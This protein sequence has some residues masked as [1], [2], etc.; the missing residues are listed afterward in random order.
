MNNFS[1]VNRKKIGIYDEI[2]Q[3]DIDVL[4]SGIAIE[5]SSSWAEDKEGA[6]FVLTPEQLAQVIEFLQ[7]TAQQ[8]IQA[9][10]L[11]P[12]CPWCLTAHG[13]KENPQCSK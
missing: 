7:A 8:V 6:V 10:L 11:P 5:I 13:T 12:I 9:E 3:L 2:T 4:Q 1:I